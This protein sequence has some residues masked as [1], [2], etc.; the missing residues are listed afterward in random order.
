[1]IGLAKAGRRV[2]RL[3]GDPAEIRR[4]DEIAAC[5]AAGIAVEIV[6]GVIGLPPTNGAKNQEAAGAGRAASAAE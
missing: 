5:H 6:P 2:V 3:D 4:A 1:M